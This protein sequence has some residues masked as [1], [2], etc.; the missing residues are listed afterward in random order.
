MHQGQMV[1]YVGGDSTGPL[2]SVGQIIDI[3]DS[4]ESAHVLWKSGSNTG[5]IGL[6]RYDDLSPNTTHEA[7]FNQSLDDSLDYGTIDD[8]LSVMSSIDSSLD[9]E[10]RD[11]L[12]EAVYEAGERA[13]RASLSTFSESLYIKTA[14]SDLSNHHSSLLCKKYALKAMREFLK[15]VEED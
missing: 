15:R 5:E 2:H 11:L 14:M 9:Y 6:Y 10:Q 4:S 7:A 8:D 13:W 1:T 12:A 3:D